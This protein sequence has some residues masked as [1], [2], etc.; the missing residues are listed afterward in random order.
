M[1]GYF[2]AIYLAF[3]N[4]LNTSLIYSYPINIGPHSIS[5]F[6]NYNNGNVCILNYN[7]VYSTFYK[8]S[9]DNKEYQ[10]K[11]ISDTIWL[12]KNR[13]SAPNIVVGVYNSKDSDVNYIC[14]LRKVANGRFKMLNIFANPNNN[15][16]DDTLLFE[17][18]LGFCNA[19]KY[20]LNIEKLKEI[21]N[22]KYYLTYLYSYN[23]S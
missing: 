2:L 14:L 16:E 1:K 17:N 18:I 4:I 7:N 23:C 9:K 13:F 20:S 5:K 19:N 10:E 8:W 22:S 12:N 3:V 21:D 15:L 6:G 11:I